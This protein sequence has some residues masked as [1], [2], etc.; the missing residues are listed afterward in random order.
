MLSWGFKVLDEGVWGLGVLVHKR[1][2]G[3]QVHGVVASA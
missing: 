3:L 1:A 2:E